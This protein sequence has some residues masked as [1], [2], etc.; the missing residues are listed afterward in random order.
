[1]RTLL[2]GPGEPADDVTGNKKLRR[3]ARYFSEKYALRDRDKDLRRVRVAA[4]SDEARAES[5]S[6]VLELH[7]QEASLSFVPLVQQQ[8]E[9]QRKLFRQAGSSDEDETDVQQSLSWAE[10]GQTFEEYVF[11]KTREFNELTRERSVLRSLQLR[12]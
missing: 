2:A 3:G 10:E 7:A 4:Q 5:R 11:A 6:K 9:Q 1:M 12:M 8:Q